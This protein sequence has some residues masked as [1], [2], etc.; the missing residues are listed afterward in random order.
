M[1]RIL[2]VLSAGVLIVVGSPILQAFTSEASQVKHPGG[3]DPGY[4]QSLCQ[5]R[6]FMCL[7]KYKSI[8]AHGQYTGHDE[9]TAQFISHRPGSGGAD[10]TYD[11]TLPRNAKLKPQQ[12]GSGGTY[13]FQRRA[14]FWLSITMCDT[15]SAPN[16]TK[17][18]HPNDDANA[19]FRSADPRSPHYLGKSPGNAF[20]ELQ[21]YTPGW[22]PQFDGFGCSARQWCAN[23]TIDSLSDDQNTGVPQNDDCLDNHFLVGEEPINWAYITRDGRSQAPANPLALSDDPSFTGLNPDLSKDLLMNPGDRLRIH[24][25]DTQAGYR[26]DITDRTTGEHGSMTASI[27]NGFGH[28]LYEPNATKCHVEPYAFHPMYDSAVPRGTT[29]AA[30]TTNVGFSDEIG[31]FE[32]CDAID[33]NGVCTDPGGA[34]STVDVDDQF[35]LDGADFGAFIP[36]IGCVLDDGDFDGVSYQRSWP[37]SMRDRHNDRKLTGTPV[38][39][40]V[41][42]TRGH[43]LEQVAF[44]T[45]LPRI[46]RGEPGNPNPQCDAQ[47]GANCVNPPPGAAFYP[48]YTST[49]LH[50]SHGRHGKPAKG[51]KHQQGKAGTRG[52]AQCYLQQGGPFLKHTRNTFG[53]TSATEYGT[54]VLFV[55]YPDV[56]FKPITLTEDFRRALTRPPCS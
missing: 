4:Q 2:A 55:T 26:V 1:R 21:F 40:T 19:A 38:Q 41:P 23:M 3:T 56:G 50:G 15:E 47:T 30:H 42:R 11:V 22:V 13:D 32:Y 46:E 9:P 8:G 28:I 53:G 39:F 16:F 36:I 29:W 7:D 51:G 45:D 34:D 27:A 44:E 6:P 37:G 18:C 49:L 14:T 24:M 33:A 17:T 20:M 25:H 48:I 12:D 35:C 31:H 52:A 54:H 43:T 5:S 10:L